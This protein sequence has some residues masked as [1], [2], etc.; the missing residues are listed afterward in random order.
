[1]RN[2]FLKYEKPIKEQ[3]YSVGALDDNDM[4]SVDDNVLIR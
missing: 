1:M 2:L 3:R 4:V